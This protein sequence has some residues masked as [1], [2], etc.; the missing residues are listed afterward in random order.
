MGLLDQA[1]ICTVAMNKIPPCIEDPVKEELCIIFCCCMKYPIIQNRRLMQRCA[2]LMMEKA[3]TPGGPYKHAVPYNMD[4][5]E[6][7]ETDAQGRWI[8]KT[9]KSLTGREGGRV[10]KIRIPDV[11]IYDENGNRSGFYDMKFPGDRWRDNQKRDY[12]ELMGGDADKVT[13]LDKNECKC[14]DR[15]EDRSKLTQE[16][17]ESIAEEANKFY[18][19]DWEE[20]EG[21][22]G[23]IVSAY[24]D[25]ELKELMP[26][27]KIA[28][29][30]AM[31]VEQQLKPILDLATG[32][33]MRKGGLGGASVPG[34]ILP[35][36]GII[37][38][39]PV[40][41]P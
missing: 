27:M 38:S 19:A 26:Q 6:P 40:S 35:R 31:S 41:V 16:Q 3:E 2:D 39:P 23:N 25:E 13:K 34:K 28:A 9:L 12:E 7:L 5:L 10:G 24:G 18:I 21:L 14:G 37:L 32:L 15:Q 4:T 11:T 20:N 36:P 17:M 33:M 22:I 8:Y 29:F 1:A 30:H